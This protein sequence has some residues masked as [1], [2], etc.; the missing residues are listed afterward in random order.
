MRTPAEVALCRIANS[1]HIP[2]PD[3][4]SRLN[5][6]NKEDDIVVYCKS[7]V[8]SANAR[9]LLLQNGFQHVRNL[10]GGIIAWSQDIDSSLN[11][12]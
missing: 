5:D 12:Y 4:L 3:L 8:R 2:L 1:Q 10:E 6:L 7:G 11:V 9:Q